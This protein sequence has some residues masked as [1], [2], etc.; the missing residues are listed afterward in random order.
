MSYFA[1]KV[2]P[3]FLNEDVLCVFQAD[4]GGEI[5]SQGGGVPQGSVLAPAGHRL[6]CAGLLARRNQRMSHFDLDSDLYA[7]K[8]TDFHDNW[9]TEIS[10]LCP[11]TWLLF[12]NGYYN[13]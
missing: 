10:G 12:S 3:G 8:V 9:H 7:A 11:G 6:Q 2:I 1:T 5:L 4:F 13:N